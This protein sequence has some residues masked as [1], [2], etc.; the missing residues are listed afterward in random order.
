MPQQL[1]VEKAI[2]TSDN[3]VVEN[4]SKV[5]DSILMRGN[6]LTVSSLF[7]ITDCNAPLMYLVVRTIFHQV[8]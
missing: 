8:S 1:A 5:T 7:K 3:N 2:T 4:D 6:L